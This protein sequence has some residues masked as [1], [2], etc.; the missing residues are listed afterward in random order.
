MAPLRGPD[1]ADLDQR[2]RQIFREIVEAYLAG[3]DPIGSQTLAA[4]GT[5]GLSSASIRNTMAALTSSGL[6]MSP[7]KSAGRIP[8]HSGLRLFVDGLLQFGDLDD[9]DRADIRGRLSDRPIEQ[10][11]DEASKMLSG[12]AGGAGLVLAPVQDH[13][14]RHVEFVPLSTTEAMAVLVYENGSVENRIMTVPAGTTPSALTAAGNF[15]SL[16][17]KG[18]S[19]S[20]T[21]DEILQEIKHHDHELDRAAKLMI[22]DGLAHWSD[23]PD[24][25]RT[26]I[27]RG[28]SHL[29]E[30][31]ETAENLERIRILLDELEQKKELI[32]LLDEAGKAPGVKIYIGAENPLFS[33]SGSSVVTAPYMNASGRVLGAIGVIGPTRINYARV[34]PMVDYTAQALGFLMRRTTTK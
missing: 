16:R 19:L 21:R 8:T 33:L 18:R 15:L 14:L 2:S 9:V 3:G 28:R 31:I 7:H 20:G 6:L 24:G 1:I 22:E 32:S 4:T 13:A 26:L 29:I 25:V 34:I 10:A 30:D 23:P 5:S 17:L 12:L 27:V 11:L